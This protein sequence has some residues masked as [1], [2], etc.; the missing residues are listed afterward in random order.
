[1]RPFGFRSLVW[2]GLI[3]AWLGCSK[4]TSEPAPTAATEPA[5]VPVTESV[6][7]TYYYLPG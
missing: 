7:V 4:D 1:M 3:L 5:V 2:A 6:E